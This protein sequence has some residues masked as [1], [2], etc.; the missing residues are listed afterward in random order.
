MIL[1]QQ[2]AHAE[3]DGDQGVL[4][5]DFR[6]SQDLVIDSDQ[7]ELEHWLYLNKV[8]VFKGKQIVKED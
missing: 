5:R 7:S 6:L 1:V 8:L 4:V 2:P 3:Q